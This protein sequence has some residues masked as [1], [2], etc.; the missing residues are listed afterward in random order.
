MKR[1]TKIT[2]VS[3]IILLTPITLIYFFSPPR[4]LTIEI[5]AEPQGV[6]E[7]YVKTTSARNNLHGMDVKNVDA[8]L[9]PINKKITIPLNR[10]KTLWFGRLSVNIHHPEYFSEGESA[11]NSYAFPSMQL[12]PTAWVKILSSDEA[13]IDQQVYRPNGLSY[14]DLPMESQVYHLWIANNYTFDLYMK[15]NDKQQI[16]KSYDVMISNTEQYLKGMLEENMGEYGETK[17]MKEAVEEVY[18]LT[19]EIYGKI[20]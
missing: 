5:I 14:R 16:Q 18:K 7:F 17:E 13:I 4:N 15:T 20:N 8:R 6:Q 12:T 11:D 10:D 1:K 19:N 3:T 9:V 2:I